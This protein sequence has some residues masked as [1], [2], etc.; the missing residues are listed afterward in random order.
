M[1]DANVES[2]LTQLCYLQ[3]RNTLPTEYR[4]LISDCSTITEVWSRLEERVP[5][6]SIKYEIITQFRKLAP[7]PNKRTP[8]ML[9]EFANA[10]SL[11]CRR[12][13]DLGFGTENYSCI[14]M[15]DIYERLDRNTTLRYRSRIELKREL[16]KDAVEDLE[17]LSNFIRSE[18]TTLEMSEGTCQEQ[19]E[20]PKRSSDVDSLLDGMKLNAV[21]KIH[22]ENRKE[23]SIPGVTKCVLGCAVNHRLIDCTIYTNLT[24]DQRREF[25]RTSYRCYICLGTGHSSR[26]CTKTTG[27]VKYVL[28]IIIIGRYVHKYTTT[29]RDVFCP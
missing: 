4:I 29:C 21:D 1:E 7:L 9:R 3:N 16:G 5:K 8:L 17:S 15:Q 19:K 25:I 22:E 20:T 6:E 13:T 23:E 26:G 28:Q 10:I 14:I 11:F 18:A 27:S 2:E 24:S 12:M